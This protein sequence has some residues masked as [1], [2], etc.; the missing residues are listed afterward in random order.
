MTNQISEATG[1]ESV[2]EWNGTVMSLGFRL[3]FPTVK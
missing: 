1:M 2:L 3:V